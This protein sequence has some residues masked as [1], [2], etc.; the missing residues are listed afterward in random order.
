[1]YCETMSEILGVYS[2]E[3]KAKEK[4]LE[5]QKVFGGGA[6]GVV[7]SYTKRDIE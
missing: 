1:M 6:S 5:F 4:I 2:T 7:V 3:D